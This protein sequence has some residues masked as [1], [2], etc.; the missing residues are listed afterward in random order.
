MGI[1]VC[2]SEK[3]NKTLSSFVLTNRMRRL[4]LK[5]FCARGQNWDNMVDGCVQNVHNDLTVG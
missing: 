1:R 2:S 4:V 3:W 5:S